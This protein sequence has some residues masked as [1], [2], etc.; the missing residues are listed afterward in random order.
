MIGG[1]IGIAMRMCRGSTSVA[2]RHFCIHGSRI[3]GFVY[4]LCIWNWSV[5]ICCQAVFVRCK[6][7]QFQIMTWLFAPCCSFSF[8]LSLSL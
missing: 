4:V 8:A 7:R 5:I 3:R 1:G 6:I 2:C